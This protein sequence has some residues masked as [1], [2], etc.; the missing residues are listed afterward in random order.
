MNNSGRIGIVS[1]FLAVARTARGGGGM[2]TV[3]GGGA[4]TNYHRTIGNLDEDPL[5]IIAGYVAQP[6]PE[7]S[8]TSRDLKHIMVTSGIKNVRTP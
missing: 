7:E 3:G 6:R 5:Q 8:P 4:G 1:G 2:V